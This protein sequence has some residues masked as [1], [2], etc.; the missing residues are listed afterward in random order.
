M[1]VENATYHGGFG[2]K[3]EFVMQHCA[4]GHEV[5]DF[6]LTNWIPPITIRT[7]SSH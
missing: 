6:A 4:A 5:V 7:A 1:R 2:L 3:Q